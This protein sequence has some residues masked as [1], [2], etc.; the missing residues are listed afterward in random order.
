MTP[1]QIFTQTVSETT[2]ST[3]TI[4]FSV[5]K[6]QFTGKFKNSMKFN[7]V[8]FATDIDMLFHI[9]TE[10]LKKHRVKPDNKWDNQEFKGV[11]KRYKLP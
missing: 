5:G 7:Q 2:N 6:Q 9:M 3:P 1:E 10:H 8:M 11:K 4:T